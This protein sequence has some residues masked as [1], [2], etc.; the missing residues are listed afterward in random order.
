VLRCVDYGTEAAW[1]TRVGF[2]KRKRRGG[3]VRIGTKGNGMVKEK[4][5]EKRGQN[6]MIERQRRGGRKLRKEIM[7][8]IDRN[9]KEVRKRREGC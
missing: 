5:S 8:K 7:K 6:R 3:I 9:Q 1:L 4:S 2:G